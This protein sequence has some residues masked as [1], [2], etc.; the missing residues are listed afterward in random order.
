MP[1]ILYGCGTWAVT[2]REEHRQRVFENGVLRKL[3][4]PKRE[5]ITGGSI[6]LHYEEHHLYSSQNIIQVI[7][8]KRKKWVGLVAHMEDR[9]GA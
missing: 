1:V 3:F 7:Q 5:E 4:W 2:L 8:S 6:L 9:K